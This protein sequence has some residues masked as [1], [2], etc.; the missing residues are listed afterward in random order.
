MGGIY[1]TLRLKENRH[2]SICDSLYDEVIHLVNELKGDQSGKVYLLRS[3]KYLFLVFHKN[4]HKIGNRYEM[5]FPLGF[6]SC[7]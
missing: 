7:D 6:L 3:Y 2:L 4:S 1:I 5:Q